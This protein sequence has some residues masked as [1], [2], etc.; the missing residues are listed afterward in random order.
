MTPYAALPQKR[1][2]KGARTLSHQAKLFH[3]LKVN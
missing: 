1:I 2:M 3:R